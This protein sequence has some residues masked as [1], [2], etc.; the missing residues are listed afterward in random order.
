MV[1]NP[2]GVLRMAGWQRLAVQRATERLGLLPGE[3]EEQVVVDPEVQQQGDAVGLVT[4][5]LDVLLRIGIDLAEQYGLRA[6]HGDEVAHVF[7]QPVTLAQVATAGLAHHV[8]R[9]VDAKARHAQA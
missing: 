1:A 8:H 4:E 2:Q 9:G 6:A 3:G 5:V 7:Q